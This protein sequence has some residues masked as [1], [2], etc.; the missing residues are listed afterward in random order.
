MMINTD[1]DRGEV[2]IAEQYAPSIDCSPSYPANASNLGL[3]IRQ[4]PTSSKDPFSSFRHSS[5]D[6]TLAVCSSASSDSSNRSES[7]LSFLRLRELPQLPYPVP[8]ETATQTCFHISFQDGCQRDERDSSKA[9]RSIRGA[10]E[11]DQR[12]NKPRQLEQTP[13]GSAQLGDGQ[14]GRKSSW[15]ATREAHS[16]SGA[17]AD[18]MTVLGL[19]GLQGARRLARLLASDALESEAGWEKQLDDA[20]PT[21]SRSYILR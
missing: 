11:I 9:E 15:Y 8:C 19:H 21:D 10:G 18:E 7:R 13:A 3:S 6:A 1:G 16:W 4:L 12:C 5:S 14:A 20:D 17:R 2:G